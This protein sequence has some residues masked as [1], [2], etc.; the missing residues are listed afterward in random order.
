MKNTDKENTAKSVSRKRKLK[1]GALA[2]ALAAVVIALV[3]L[4]NAMLTSFISNSVRYTDLTNSQ[5]YTISETAKEYLK[6]IKEERNIVTLFKNI[7]EPYKSI[8]YKSDLLYASLLKDPSAYIKRQL[9]GP[10]IVK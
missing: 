5:I 9:E 4:G 6:Q 8:E 7:P 1:Y 10:V 3:I 2:A